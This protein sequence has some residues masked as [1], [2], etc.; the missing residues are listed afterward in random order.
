MSYKF[1]YPLLVNEDVFKNLS[2]G[3]YVYAVVQDALKKPI[4]IVHQVH[5]EETHKV[6]AGYLIERYRQKVDLLQGIY[7]FGAGK[8]IVA[9]KGTALEW[10]TSKDFGECSYYG[11]HGAY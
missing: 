7:V 6:R 1:K 10:N 5:E 11:A 9:Q 4:L 8:L 2:D 3:L